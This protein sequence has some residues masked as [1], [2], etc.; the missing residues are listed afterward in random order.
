MGQAA[1]AMGMQPG[2][3]PGQ[4][5]APGTM[6]G[7]MPGPAVPNV[8][9]VDPMDIGA[10]EFG[11]GGAGG[12]AAPRGDD[13]WNMLGQRERDALYQ[14][15]IR[16]LPPEYRELLG[17]YFEALSKESPRAPRRPGAGAMEAKP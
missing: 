17:D 4:A 12:K 9:A 10:R 8:P 15:Y 13:H 7:M 6:P 3:M 1:Q 2:Q 5:M 16:Q 11:R 14:K